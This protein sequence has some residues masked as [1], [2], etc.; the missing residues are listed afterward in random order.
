MDR[1][2]VLNDPEEVIRAALFAHQAG[3]WT[4]MPGIIQSFD[5][6]KMT[7][8]VQ[9]TIQ[10][11]QAILDPTTPGGMQTKSVNMPLLPDCPVIFP[12]G[13]GVTLTFPIKAGDECLVVLANRCID[14]WWQQGGIQPPM[15]ARMHD[16][17]DGFVIVGPRSQPRVLAGVSTALATLRSDDGTTSVSL[18]PTGHIVA[19]TA[20]GGINLTGPVAMTGTVSITGVLN[21]SSAILVGGVTVVVP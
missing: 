4:A 13:G 11:T 17:S 16:L 8:V 6:V 7:A 20:P 5:P 3:V 2:E 10:G 19:I 12:S 9:P 1:R 18:D 21:V 15:E 14:A